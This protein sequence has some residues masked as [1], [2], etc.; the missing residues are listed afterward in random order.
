MKK[1]VVTTLHRALVGIIVLSMWFGLSACAGSI[2]GQIYFDDNSNGTMDLGESPAP[3]VLVS[4]IKDGK[5][6][7]RGYSD[8]NGA[9]RSRSKGPGEYCIKTDTALVE[10]NFGQVRNIRSKFMTADSSGNN[11]TDANLD[12]VCDIETPAEDSAGDE[13]QEGTGTSEDDDSSDSSDDGSDVIEQPAAWTNNGHCQT[14]KGRSL[15]VNIGVSIDYAEAFSGFPARIARTVHPGEVF[16]TKIFMPKGCELKDLFLDERLKVADGF[17]GGV[18]NPSLNRVTFQSSAPNSSNASAMKIKSSSG[19]PS[20][21]I[22]DL[23]I[24]TLKLE[25]NDIDE[26]EVKVTINPHALCGGEDFALPVIPVTITKDFDLTVVMNK[27]THNPTSNGPVKF[28][29]TVINDGANSLKGGDLR[30]TIPARMRFTEVGT[31]CNDLG[32]KALCRVPEIEANSEVKFQLTSKLPELDLDTDIE[33]RAN[34][35][36]GDFEIDAESITFTV[37]IPY[38]EE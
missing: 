10:E 5:E 34:Y 29:V 38:E 32:T 23:D 3:F 16:E 17:S 33:I 21:S 9:F 19:S 22:R 30:I 12:G 1:Q 13:A 25:A 26:E 27:L 37:I 20:I 8:I 14:I 11:C 36:S 31:K 4:I 6:I 28:T 7:D 18:F 15:N 2:D 24:F 35:K